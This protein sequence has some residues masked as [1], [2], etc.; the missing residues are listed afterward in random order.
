MGMTVAG[1]LVETL[2]QLGVEQIF[3]LI[4][5]SLNPLADVVRRSSIEWV[6]VR[7]EEGA[8]LAAAGQAKLT[9]R[10]AVCCGTTG[11]GSTHLVAGLYEA[12]RDHAPCWPCLAT[13]RASS[14]AWTTSSRRRPICSSATWRFIRKRSRPASRRRVSFTR[15][16]RPR[17]GGT[18]RRPSDPAA[19]RAVGTC[20]PCDAKP[21]DAAAAPR[22]IAAG[23][24]CRGDGAPPRGGVERRAPVRRGLPRQ[25][26][27]AGRLVGPPGRTAGAHRARQGTAA[28]RRSPLDGR[29]GHDRHA[30]LLRRRP[31]MRPA[32]H[33]RYRL[34]LCRLSPGPRKHDPDR[35]SSSSA[36]SPDADRV[37]TPRFGQAESEVHPG[38]GLGKEGDRLLRQGR[39]RTQAL[40]RH[41]RQ[42]GSRRPEQGPHPSQAV[43][44]LA[45]D[46][47]ARD[48]VFV[49]DTGSIPCGRPIGFASMGANGSSARS[50]TRPSA[51]RW[52]RATAFRCSTGRGRW[53]C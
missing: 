1:I 24:G 32:G 5:D 13:C 9:G 42:A 14:E 46:L 21:R 23:L 6:G 10:L 18:G 45:S 38:A 11:P 35:S 16:S 19:G 15:P 30:G 27:S 28:V 53:W 4:G 44:R 25:R 43:A 31:A 3:G 33:G 34:P 48:A 49:L 40:E 22:G 37:R 8:A 41:A 12:A 52:G 20:R 7:H 36:R 51:P 29:P 26:R 17:D 39:A 47:A 50:T 2:E